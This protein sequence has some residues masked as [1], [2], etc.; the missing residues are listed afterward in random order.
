MVYVVVSPADKLR[1]RGYLGTRVHVGGATKEVSL[2][3]PEDALLREALEAF[4]SY[5]GDPGKGGV[6]PTVVLV[7]E[8][9][10]EAPIG[11]R[12]H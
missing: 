8:D 10:R 5:I 1:V 2:T 12:P 9:I 4:R 3:S 11:D 6:A 7:L